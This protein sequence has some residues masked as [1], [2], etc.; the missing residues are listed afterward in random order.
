MTTAPDPRSGARRRAR[1]PVLAALVAVAVGLA[2]AGT[3]G[4]VT[5]AGRPVA[6]GDRQAEVAAKGQQIMPFDLERTTHVFDDR[7][8]GGIQTVIADDP[9]D[10]GQISLIRSHLRDEADKFALGDFTDPASIHGE[11]MP[12]LAHLRDGAERIQVHYQDLP[13]GA[14]ITYTTSDPTLVQALHTWFKAQT[15][16]HGRHAEHTG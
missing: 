9:T 13:E 2:A 16:D 11:S 1:L 3:W 5:R 7:P 14:R 10:S 4:V 6:T 12:G 15:A 8:D